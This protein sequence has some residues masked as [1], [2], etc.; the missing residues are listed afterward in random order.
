MCA[1]AS[2]MRLGRSSW[3]PDVEVKML[4]LHLRSEGSSCLMRSIKAGTMIL[5]LVSAC[6]TQR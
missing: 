4:A 1:L 5:S 2:L 3:R 6:Q